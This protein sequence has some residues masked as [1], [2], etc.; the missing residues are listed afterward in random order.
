METKHQIVLNACSGP[1]LSFMLNGRNLGMAFDLRA[2]GTRPCFARQLECL[3]CGTQTAVCIWY[4]C[5]SSDYPSS[6]RLNLRAGIEIPPLQP[7][8]CQGCTWLGF[9]TV[10][11][12]ENLWRKTGVCSIWLSELACI[13]QLSRCFQSPQCSETLGNTIEWTGCR[14]RIF[15]HVSALALNFHTLL[16]LRSWWEVGLI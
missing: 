2:E 15:R 9:S 7:H 8:I 1:R 16:T 14:S 12:S 10:F 11:Y 5:I 3:H 13:L 4:V 6:W